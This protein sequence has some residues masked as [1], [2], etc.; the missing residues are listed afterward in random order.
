MLPILDLDCVGVGLERTGAM[1]FD[2][3][4]GELSRLLS[5]ELLARQSALLLSLELPVECVCTETSIVT[6]FE[7][8]ISH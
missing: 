3:T 4:Q 6:V 5:S 7:E 8:T 2:A 1:I